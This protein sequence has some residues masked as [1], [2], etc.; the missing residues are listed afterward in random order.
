[1]MEALDSELSGDLAGAARMP[2]FGGSSCWVQGP[3]RL[4]TDQLKL[5]ALAE[6][7][8]IEPGSVH[9]MQADPPLN[10]FRLGFSSVPEDRIADGIKRLA[11]LIPGAMRN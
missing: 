2:G 4:D 8:I 6:G 11:A 3:E 1:M 10:Y 7:I 9:F 5:L